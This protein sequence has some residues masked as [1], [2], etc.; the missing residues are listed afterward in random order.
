MRPGLGTLLFG[1]ALLGGGVAVTVFS[2]KVV[3]FGAIGAGLWYA[4]KGVVI[5]SR[6]GGQ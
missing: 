1:L 2:E 3:W 5:L 4:I 6:G